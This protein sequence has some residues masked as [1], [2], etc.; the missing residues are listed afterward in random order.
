MAQ[1]YPFRPKTPP[2]KS[3]SLFNMEREHT[4]IMLAAAIQASERI[5]EVRDGGFEVQDKPDNSPVTDAD[6]ASDDMIRQVLRTTGINIM[7]EEVELAWEERSSWDEFWCIDP[8]DGT[9][10]FAGGG[11]EYT[12]NIARV[13]H[14]V[15]EE[16]VIAFPAFRRIYFTSGSFARMSTWTPGEMPDAVI[17]RSTQLDGKRPTGAP[18]VATVSRSYLTPET[19]AYLEQLRSKHPD[20]E[21]DRSGSAFKFCKIIEGEA[22]IYP[23][24]GPCM[25][26][27][28]ASGHALVRRVGFDV[29]HAHT[30]EPLLYNK[31]DLTNPDFIV[32]QR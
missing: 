11:D 19:L 16:G 26:W 29:F 18:F 8:L 12:V 15:P 27:D 1:N 32:R 5:R 31:R 23:R 20:L 21:V 14:G 13:K 2:L 24:F 17:E 3:T 6:Y 30:G 25:E 10:E 4:H 7:S 22:N 28:S 9:R